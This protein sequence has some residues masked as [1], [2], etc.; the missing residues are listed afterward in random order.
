[1]R[2]IVSSS[3]DVEGPG[4]VGV[5]VDARGDAIAGVWDKVEVGV[6]TAFEAGVW[7]VA[8]GFLLSPPPV[9]LASM[10]S[11]FTDGDDASFR[12]RG[13]PLIT[14]RSNDLLARS[15]ALSLPRAAA[16]SSHAYSR[17]RALQRSSALVVWS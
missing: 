10:G 9:S 2:T 11:L 12:T 16:A 3:E 7:G 14:R 13:G 4:G 5:I 15:S 8:E 6:S 17:P 1:M